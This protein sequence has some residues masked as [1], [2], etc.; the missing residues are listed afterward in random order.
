MQELVD[1]S[2]TSFLASGWTKSVYKIV[3]KRPTLLSG[4]QYAVKIVNLEGRHIEQCLMQHKIN[5]EQCYL[6]ASKKLVKEVALLHHL[7]CPQ[8]I[9]VRKYLIL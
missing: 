9:Q 7:H 5:I 3:P 6:E 1:E 8:V 4:R 2:N